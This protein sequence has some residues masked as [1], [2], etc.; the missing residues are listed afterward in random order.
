[1]CNNQSHDLLLSEAR[2]AIASHLSA[3]S[4]AD[5]LA[6]RSP[7]C[8][9]AKAEAA[10]EKGSGGRRN[11]ATGSGRNRHRT[12]IGTIA[13]TH[14]ALTSSRPGHAD[15][16]TAHA[17]QGIGRPTANRRARTPLVGASAL[18]GVSDTSSGS[19]L[20]S[21]LMPGR[22]ILT[23]GVFRRSGSVVYIRA[24]ASPSE[25]LASS[26]WHRNP[27]PSN[28]RVGRA[29]SWPAQCMWRP[30][31]ELDRLRMLE[32]STQTRVTAIAR[33][34]RCPTAVDRQA[35]ARWFGDA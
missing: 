4:R 3:K 7:Q 20:G 8:Q 2:P 28:R 32:M 9:R 21:T 35:L 22:A 29:R 27:A 26:S 25:V 1:V 34:R 30:G 11:T 15:V 5:M 13:W 18:H 10:S 17:Q 12:R 31:S 6:T 23:R 16:T 19:H 24:D 14:L 33:T